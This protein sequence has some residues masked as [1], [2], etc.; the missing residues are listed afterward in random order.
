MEE[1]RVERWLDRGLGAAATPRRAAALIAVMTSLITVVAG[2]LVRLTDPQT[3]PSLGVG[4]WWGVQ[5][6]TT[7]GYGDYVPE[8]VTGRMVAA[9]VM[10]GGIGTSN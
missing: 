3:F 1:T 10:L 9:L 5:T 6:V 7:V 8:S 2:L 4:L